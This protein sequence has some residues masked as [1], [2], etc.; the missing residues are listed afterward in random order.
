MI[1][2]FNFHPDS[3]KA[4]DDLRLS[5]VTDAIPPLPKY[6]SIQ[7]MVE[8]HVWLSLTKVAIERF[9]PADFKAAVDAK[10]AEFEATVQSEFNKKRSAEG[11][12]A[13]VI[14]KGVVR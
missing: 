5:I 1:I 10:K 11:A 8:D 14:V 3:E 12:A 6:P 13:P 9:P 7:A 2:T 4:L